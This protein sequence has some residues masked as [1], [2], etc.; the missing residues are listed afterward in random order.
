MRKKQAELQ[1]ITKALTRLIHEGAPG[2]GGH[3]FE[4]AILICE[5]IAQWAGLCRYMS[6]A[7][8]EGRWADLQF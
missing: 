8:G 3:G 5:C 2:E 7:V 6:L 1:M 4:M